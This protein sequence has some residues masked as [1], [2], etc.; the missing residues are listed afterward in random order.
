M[1]AC[2]ESTHFVGSDS[3]DPNSPSWFS[4]VKDAARVS[5]ADSTAWDDEADLIIVGYGGAGVAAAIEGA[6]HGMQVLAVDRY[7]GGG[8]TAINGGVFYAGGGTSVQERAGIRDTTQDMFRYLKIETQGVV[9]DKT[10]Q[11]FCD[12]S[13]E[14]LD[15]L[16]QRGVKFN[17][18]LYSKKTGY[19]D[20]RFYLYYSDNSL[21]PSRAAAARP[22]PRGHRVYARPLGNGQYGQ[23]IYGPLAAAASRAG[24]RFMSNSEVS[25][26]V[27]DRSGR[28]VG[29][30]VLQIP[31]N[32]Q[33]WK[34]RQGAQR[35]A[36][37]LLVLLP[38]AF[39]G[40]RL[41]IR[42]AQK[43]LAKVI[44]L[45]RKYRMARRI[46]ARYG[47]CLSA[48]G[49]IYNRDLVRHLA[50]HHER[51]APMGNPGDDGSGIRL[52]QTAGGASDRMDHICS[53]RFL[54]PPAAWIKGI[55]VNKSGERFVDESMYA[56]SVGYAL[57]E[58][59]GGIAFLIIDREIH[60]KAWFELLFTRMLGY[61]RYPAILSMLF[62]SRKAR[63]IAK[64]AA[65]CG[66]PAETLENTIS[67][68][69]R[70]CAGVEADPFKKDQREMHLLVD[71]PFFAI[72]VSAS[73]TLLP[74]MAMT[75]GGLKVNE[76]SGEV[77]S[78]T[79]ATVSGLYA[80]GR[81]AIGVCSHVYMSGLSLA[82]CIFSGRRVGAHA[83]LLKAQHDQ[84]AERIQI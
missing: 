40:A 59:Q 55:I 57:N 23:Y 28:V 27:I 47:V 2:P 48:G 19:P 60:R 71:G 32:T 10:L 44:D 37:R 52:G 9:S 24:V 81:S 49:F 11:R 35:R 15:W 39:P 54:N 1:S 17:E 43:H 12:S 67:A 62:A 84:R 72:D 26:L 46:R 64:L 8:S 25:Q 45:D 7:E 76:D 5:D 31:P 53:W 73:N 56:S 4:A 61:Q 14:T 66:L 78:T 36:N 42:L 82:D 68:Y 77:L 30:E 6:E 51:T 74:M 41:A 83:A 13:C 75:L 18:R 3:S 50:P 22:A 65:K 33:A 20:P 29:V 63:S 58:K 21:T 80:A 16:V 34:L 70:Y 69:N 79:G 38:L